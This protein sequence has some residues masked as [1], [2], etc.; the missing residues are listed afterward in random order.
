[1]FRRIALE[2]FNSNEPEQFSL[3]SPTQLICWTR[4]INHP[5]TSCRSG[6]AH[7]WLQIQLTQFTDGFKPPTHH[8]TVNTGNLNLCKISDNHL[9]NCGSVLK[10]SSVAT[11][12]NNDLVL[13]WLLSSS[14]HY[15]SNDSVKILNHSG[16]KK[17]PNNKKPMS[18]WE[19]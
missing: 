7:T 17:N 4:S 1:M 2:I 19:C 18:G 12:K 14:G 9:V 5:D 3:N 6:L 15:E 10:S 11:T 13:Q 8:T 16:E